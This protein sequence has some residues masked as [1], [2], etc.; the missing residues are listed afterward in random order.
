M[1]PSRAAVETLSA[2]LV[3]FPDNTLPD[4]R[5]IIGLFDNADE[6]MAHNSPE[7]RPVTFEDFPVSRADCGED[8]SYET[9]PILSLRE[10]QVGTVES[11]LPVKVDSLHVSDYAGRKEKRP[12]GKCTVVPFFLPSV[13]PQPQEK[14]G[15]LLHPLGKG[16]SGEDGEKVALEKGDAIRIS[17]ETKRQF[18][19]S[20][21]SPL[22]GCIQVKKDSL[23]GYTASDAVIS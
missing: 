3:D 23:E 6:L 4:K 2:V 12:H 13:R 8:D 22:S 1:L 21:D 20:S 7:R 17:P 16:N 14:R 11:L 18:P 15:N 10:R 5:G 19:A 9:L